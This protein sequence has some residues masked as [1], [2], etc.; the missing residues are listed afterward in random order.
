MGD[1]AACMC[2]LKFNIEQLASHPKEQHSSALFKISCGSRNVYNL[3]S[4]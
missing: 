1:M 4:E 3:L 2:V